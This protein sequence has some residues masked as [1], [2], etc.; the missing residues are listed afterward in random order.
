MRSGMRTVFFVSVFSSVAVGALRP[1]SGQAPPATPLQPGS[2]VFGLTIGVPQTF[3]MRGVA[4]AERHHSASSNTYASPRSSSGYVTANIIPPSGDVREISSPSLLSEIESGRSHPSF[5]QRRRYEFGSITYFSFNFF[6]LPL[7]SGSSS[8]IHP[9][10]VTESSVGFR[11]SRYSPRSWRGPSFGGLLMT[12]LKGLN[13]GDAQ[14][15]PEPVEGGVS[16]APLMATMSV[17]PESA[18]PDA[19]AP[20]PVAAN[21]F[22]S[23]SEGR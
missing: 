21:S 19:V 9:S 2:D 14:A 10:S 18:D 20:D 3:F 17:D 5:L 15:C 12:S 8:R 4:S 13:D 6:G 7:P 16:T 1:G 22:F 11:S 23:S